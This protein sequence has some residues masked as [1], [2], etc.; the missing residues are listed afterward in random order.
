M[1]KA[2][3]FKFDTQLLTDNTD[4][5]HENFCQKVGVVRVT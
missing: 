1:V 2:T 3:D 5:T 4:M